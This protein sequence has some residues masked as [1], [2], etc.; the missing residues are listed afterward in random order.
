MELTHVLQQG[1][2][3][4]MISQRMTRSVTASKAPA[5]KVRAVD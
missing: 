2:G 4:A 3:A 1:T 5:A